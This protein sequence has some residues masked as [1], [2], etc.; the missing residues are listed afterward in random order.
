[1]NKKVFKEGILVNTPEGERLRATKCKG[2]GT[3]VFPAEHI[4]YKCLSEDMEEITLSTHG[5]LYSFT[6]IYRPVNKYKVPHA[7]GYIDLPEQIRVF[8]PLVV[9]DPDSLVRGYEYTCGADADMIIDTLWV[10]DDG[11]EIYGYKF[12]TEQNKG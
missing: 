8:T 3:V 11:T 6:V 1:M 10:E 5:K 4:C 9:E 2:C 12:K 7:V